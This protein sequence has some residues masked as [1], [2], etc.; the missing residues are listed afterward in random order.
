MGA[1]AGFAGR[2][3][4]LARFA[5]ALAGETRLLLVVGDAGVGKTRFV[6]EALRAA[7]ADGV[8]AAWGGCLPL[9]EKLPLL[10]V[11]QALGELSRRADGRLLAEAL[12]AAPAY[13]RTEMVR[14]VPGLEPGGPGEGN[15][16]N[17][18]GADGAAGVWQRDRLFSAVADVL[19]LV[20][21]R[22]AVSVVIEDAHWADSATL[23]CLTYLLRARGE[24]RLTVVATCRSDEAPLD[25]HVMS[26][27]ANV[28]GSG[29]VEEIRLGPLSRAEVGDQV[30]A[31]AGD[32]APDRLA[33]EVFA[34]AEGNP[35]FTEQLVTA[36]LADGPDSG[37]GGAGGNWDSAAGGT[38][39]GSGQSAGAGGLGG[40]PSALPVRLAELL[41]ARSGRCGPD[42]QAVLAALSV[43][44]RPLD[45]AALAD[46]AGQDPAA[47]RRGL[48]E[49]AA[50]RLL[51][52]PGI[53]PAAGGAGRARVAG[54][55][56]ASRPRH[57]LL[58]EAVAGA[59]LP[60][61]RA[62]LHE[63]AAA[64]LE[65]AGDDMLAAEAAGH[66]L[67]AGRP[68]REL[69][70]RVVAGQAAERVF[71]YA[72]AAAHFQRAI[73]LR[74]DL[75]DLGDLPAVSAPSGTGPPGSRPPEAGVPSLPG[76]YVRA[77]DVLA[78]AGDSER[79]GALAEEAY[80]LFAGHPD[81]ATAAVVI[82]R[83][84]EFRV[85]SRPEAGLELLQEAIGL[86]SDG[87]PS[88]FEAE[89]WYRY[90]RVF[91][92]T[93]VGDQE[94]SRTAGE[95]AAKIAEAAGAAGLVP[96]SLVLL[97]ELAQ[98]RGDAEEER[99]LLG[100]ARGLA[101]AC[102]DGESLL[103]I[104]AGECYRHVSSG[105][106]EAALDAGLAG[107][108]TA[109][110]LGLQ[111]GL[112][113]VTLTANACA[114]LVE[115]GQTAAAGGLVD[116]LTSGP[117]DR[118][119]VYLHLCRV[120]IDM[121]RGDLDAA[122][123]RLR[124]VQAMTAGQ[125]GGFRGEDYAPQL[126]ANLALWTG[127]PG[128]ALAEVTRDLPSI[129]RPI[130]YTGGPL[131]ILGMRACADLAETARARRDAAAEAD[132][133][134]AAADLVSWVD[135]L[136][137][138]PFIDI[139]GQVYP[140]AESA[141]WEAERDR[142]TG[143]NNPDA[144][145]AAAKAWADIGHTNRAAYAWWRQAQALLYAGHSAAVSAPALRAAAKAAVHHAPLL[146]QVH[147]LAERARVGL[148]EPAASASGAGPAAAT[149]PDRYGL[150]ARELSVLRLL[151]RGRTNAQIGTELY[152]SPKTASVHVTSI[153]RKL[154]VSSR[155]QA[156]AVA[157]RA[158]LL[159]GPQPAA[160]STQD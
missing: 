19:A 87:P 37:V 28:R 42:G 126:A 58:A 131:L 150:T 53:G 86:V 36:A 76:L 95:R 100:R 2:R 5:R 116:P 70:A 142:L 48:R 67:A 124:Q 51:A 46:V 20:A 83:A 144:W 140:A 134:A 148:S 57:T 141:T 136:P 66:W 133:M 69:P 71:G 153:F 45:E 72:E 35:F 151:A 39:G 121:L 114:V 74:R 94:T 160:P 55:A 80:A 92:E 13:A 68:D 33:D 3:G 24:A 1:G 7:A 103:W 98:I 93:G 75:P 130:M 155:A 6:T 117:P 32:A 4:E 113:A 59:L 22:S 137:V 43:A 132:A 30:A 115:T 111:D 16:G 85:R 89:A 60:G 107:L 62:V 12:S 54:P 65:S 135:R 26:W 61:E 9:A 152:M 99:V 158:G 138:N 139:P 97:A 47:V 149:E 79:A 78:I 146:A 128:E 31:L 44:S 17:A 84:A 143:D 63:R 27:L 29:P 90:G 23:D 127:R 125:V 106:P 73:T 147:V 77:V 56:G 110:L 123:R 101:E 156:A 14:L 118:H 40:V 122:W 102:G 21:A 109:R 81:P 25:K 8:I 38:A 49:L 50:A 41:L 159:D 105:R 145:A 108:R 88:A 82:M 119:R 112:P 15:G 34:R 157:E 104:A 18:P 52:E 10:P 11:A 154:G 129:S 64:T 91:L 96:R 120:E